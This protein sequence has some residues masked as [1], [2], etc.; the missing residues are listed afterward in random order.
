MK[1]VIVH[2][3]F[4]GVI[5][6]LPAGCSQEPAAA[7][8][9]PAAPP[10][11]VTVAEVVVTDQPLVSEYIGLT[12]GSAEVEIRARVEGFIE[13]IHF[14]EGRFVKK[15]DLLYTLEAQPYVAL[16][17]QAGGELARAEAALAKAHSDLRRSRV[18]KERGAISEQELDDDATL[19]RTS[20]ALVRSAEA[21]LSAARIQ[22]GYS[23][24]RALADGRIG[25][26]EVQVGNLVGRGQ[27][28][29]LT[30]IS[31][32]DPIHVRFS[33]SE[34]EF[35]DW[36][37]LHPNEADARRT[38]DGKFELVLIDGSVHPHKGRAVFVDRGVDAS[39]GTILIEVAFDNP[40][41]SLRPG[42]HARVRFEKGIVQ[43]AV[44]VP[45]RAVME[46]QGKSH[47]VLAR[48]GKAELREVRPGARVGTL[49]LIESGLLPGDQ[50]VVE[51]LQKVR[52]GSVLQA[53]LVKLATDVDAVAAKG[54]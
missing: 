41:R 7:A 47:V 4:L 11:A 2:L 50:V 42:S 22:L 37:R 36:T 46:T 14:E 33:A 44:L 26:S 17:A 21:T 54:G 16:V 6:S 24:V 51:G 15:G 5:A 31:S 53:T 12:R 20:A 49:R 52:T 35:L 43:N 25:K 23:K 38:T 1:H 34:A 45:Q 10:V 9:A 8:G 27:S 19:E 13:A 39:T 30:T 28:T 3:S 48:D 29:L 18:L 32:V 40:D